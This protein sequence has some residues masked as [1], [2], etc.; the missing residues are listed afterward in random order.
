MFLNNAA[1]FAIRIS[2]TAEVSGSS[3]CPSESVLVFK[4]KAGSR[5]TDLPIRAKIA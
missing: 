1:T 4:D 5:M 2:E 3:T